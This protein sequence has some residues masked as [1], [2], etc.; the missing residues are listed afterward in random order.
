VGNEIFNRIELKL[1]MDIATYNKF[2][3]CVEP[4][5]ETDAF[6]DGDGFY[7]ISNLY[8]D[9][10]DNF[11]HEQ[12]VNREPFRQKLRMRIYGDVTI[13][14]NCF[15][16]IKKKY[17]GESNK[18]RTSMSLRDAYRFLVTKSITEFEKIDCSDDLVLQEIEYFKNYYELKPKTVIS[19]D[20]KALHCQH[21]PNVRVTFDKNLRSRNTDLRLEHGRYGDLFTPPDFV[22]MEV[23]A[24]HCIPLWFVEIIDQ[25][26]L[27]GMKFSKYSQSVMQSALELKTEDEQMLENII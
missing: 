24:I 26:G 4:R 8:F 27:S 25:F 7:S 23:K 17:R 21:D 3:K 22:L 20:R 6:G 11:F 19:Y 14:D 10:Y 2:I 15:I 5:F 18:R 16:E 1:P 12:N 13:D 9:T